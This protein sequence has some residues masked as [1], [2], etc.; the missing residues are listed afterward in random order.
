MVLPRAPKAVVFDMDGLLVDTEA[1]C[2]DVMLEAAVAMGRDLPLPVFMRMIGLPRAQ[3]DAVA[4]AHFGAGF[5]LDDFNGRV[6]AA[7]T[8][9]CAAGI[10]LKEGVTEIL[11]LLDA[12][13]LP[14]AIA[15]SAGHGTVRMQ[16]EPLGL[17]SRFDSIVANGDYVRGKPH[18]DPYLAA[19]ER[20]RVA[21]EDCLAL[22]DSHNG[23]HAAC[24]AGM[25]TVM[26]P[27]LLEPNEEMRAI[28]TAV[29]PSLHDVCAWLNPAG[30]ALETEHA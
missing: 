21:P 12:L 8:E 28:C 6:K 17:P 30:A 24:A 20:L 7:M 18:P 25:M 3:S 2:R 11:D 19:A 4:M 5:A 26:I 15:T 14:R 10:A 16:L 9:R 29:A 27:D 23:V 1:A 13:R 22:E